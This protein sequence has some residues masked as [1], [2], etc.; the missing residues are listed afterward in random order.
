[1]EEEAA[2]AFQVSSPACF[3]VTCW[4]ADAAAVDSVAADLEAVIRAEASVDS[5]AAI[6]AG[7]EPQEIGSASGNW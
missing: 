7:A 3:S 1:V 5:V 6:P 2:A 4:E